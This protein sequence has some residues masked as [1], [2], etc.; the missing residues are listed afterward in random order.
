MQFVFNLLFPYLQDI[1]FGKIKF[2]QH[3]KIIQICRL[4]RA[5]FC[6]IIYKTVLCMS[7]FIHKSSSFRI[8]CNPDTV[9]AKQ[10][11][12]RPEKRSNYLFSFLFLN[13][14]GKQQNFENLCT[15]VFIHLPAPGMFH[16]EVFYSYTLFWTLQSI[17]QSGFS[18]TDFSDQCSLLDDLECYL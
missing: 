16:L 4:M 8:L 11:R 2:K 6:Q 5:F 10:A 14:I 17:F 18:K 1:I 9:F 3:I 7:E 13:G 15:S 12:I